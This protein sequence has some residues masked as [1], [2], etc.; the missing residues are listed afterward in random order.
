[1]KSVDYP[2]SDKGLFQK[3]HGMKNHPLYRTWTNIKTRCY[4][5]N[6]KAYKN[7]GGRGIN[8]CDEWRM[9]FK[10]FHDYAIQLPHY[11]E[12]GM[13]LDRTNNDGNY[14]PDNL[15]WASRHIQAVNAR[16]HCDNT[17]GYNGVNFRKDIKKYRSRIRVNNKLICLGSYMLPEDAYM[18]RIKYILKHNLTEY[19]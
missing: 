16:L 3:Q 14:E 18:A 2:K 13:T 9:N 15:R 5:K 19:L 7:Y 6:N 11:G 17:T 12:I 8:I 10:A 1:M 4:N